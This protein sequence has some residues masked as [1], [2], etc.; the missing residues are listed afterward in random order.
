MK[1]K[2]FDI[3]LLKIEWGIFSIIATLIGYIIAITGV[4]D[5]YKNI[6]LIVSSSIFMISYIAIFLYYKFFYNRI[7][8]KIGK[9][10]IL[11]KVGNIFNEEGLKVIPVNEY[12]DTLV[13]GK[14]IIISSSSL[15]GM[16]VKKYEK[17]NNLEELDNKIDEALKEYSY[18]ENKNR[19]H[20]KKKKYE[21]GTTVVLGEFIL[22]ALTKFD[23]NNEASLSMQ[24][25]LIF[26]NKFWNEI[27]RVHNGRIINVPI[28]GSGMSRINP[29]L[30]NQEYLEQII[31]SLKTST[32]ITSKSRVNII[33]YEL[34]KNEI[35]L[36]RLNEIFKNVN[37]K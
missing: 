7:K 31:W 8:L 24:E 17:N 13:D 9:V 2:F 23:N 28:I 14:D 27:N 35:S 5:K 18:E 12:F 21:I 3:S 29:V 15:H 34:E 26:L 25:Y 30:S 10:E 36:L 19:K 22:T 20:G 1:Q 11:I 16:Y 4:E 37:K 6:F 33:I 32:L